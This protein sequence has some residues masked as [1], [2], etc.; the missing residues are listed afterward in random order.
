MLYRRVHRILLARADGRASSIAAGRDG[1]GRAMDVSCGGKR[2]QLGIDTDA[3]L[4]S[5]A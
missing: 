3:A 4:G 2:Q 5:A 1:A